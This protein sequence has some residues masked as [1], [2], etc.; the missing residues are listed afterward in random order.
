MSLK[1]T[2]DRIKETATPRI[3]DQ[4]APARPI[5]LPNNPASIEPSSGA[6]TISIYI[7]FISPIPASTFQCVQITDIDGAPVSEQHHQDRQANGGL[8]SGHGQ[9]KEY[10]YLAGGIAKIVR[11]RHKVHITRQQHQFYRHQ[12]DD[13]VF[14]VKKNP[15]HADAEQ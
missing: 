4:C 8:G 5:L 2:T 1:T 11:E 14:T 3:A 9:N 6:S 15:R 10:K 12:D 7:V 13:D